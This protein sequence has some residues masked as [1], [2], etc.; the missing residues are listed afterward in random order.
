MHIRELSIY[1]FNSFVQTSSLGTYYQTLSYAQLMGE[2]GYDY[3]FIGYVNEYDQI[4][5]ASLIVR[6][7][8]NHVK[9]GYAPR[10]FILDYFNS[11]LLKSFTED[12][13]KYYKKKKLIFIK[14]NPE[15]VI[16]EVDA[17][18]GL[19][20]Y[21]WN[22]EIRDILADNGYLKLKDNLYFEST[23]PRYQAVVSLKNFDFT[24]VSKNT[25]N[26]VRKGI[27]KGLHIEIADASGIDI[28]NRFIARK[29]KTQEFYYK[30]YYHL[31]QR[32]G[33]IDLFLVSVDSTEYLLHSRKMYEEELN[34][35][36]YYQEVIKNKP[37]QK[38]INIKME[39]D[40]Q[41]LAYKND[42]EIATKLNKTNDKL[43]VA[44]ALVMKYQNRVHILISGYDTRYKHFDPN[45]Y[46][47][48]AIMDYYKEQFDYIDLN[49]IT[50]D[51]TDENPYNG[52]NKFK[53]GFNPR[54]YEYIGEYDLPINSRK[55]Y[56]LRKKGELAKIFNKTDIKVIDK[57]KKK[58]ELL[59]K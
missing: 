28:L 15:I 1:E 52:L 51:F 30:D 44:G 37:S 13:I 41:L 57:N 40:R 42:I 2:Y 29:K 6:R 47:H 50:G 45:Y 5:V 20:T 18:N 4:K 17:Q 53:L 23:L 59:Q 39:S 38:N 56:H 22:Y 16:S 10:G 35:N 14:L 49:G 19:A 24:K 25:R 36:Q 12:L 48:Y 43:Y 58:K 32:D 55:Y 8:I 34:R 33:M 11:N 9:Y 26:K 27:S 3:D 54:V 7:S 31:F 21:N 46:L